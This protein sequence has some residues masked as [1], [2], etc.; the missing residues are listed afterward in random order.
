MESAIALGSGDIRD[1]IPGLIRQLEDDD[2][3]CVSSAA[4]ALGT[5]GTDEAVAALITALRD[6][7]SDDKRRGLA[8]H[9]LCYTANPLAIEP[10]TA[11]LKDRSLK[12]YHLQA[13][14]ALKKLGED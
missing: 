6:T 14:N 9:G 5:I 7:P 10:L 12:S 3:R 4:A 2:L 13:K 1:A 11:A 8:L